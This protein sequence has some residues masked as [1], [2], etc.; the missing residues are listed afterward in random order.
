MSGEADQKKPFTVPLK[1]KNPSGYFEMHYPKIGCRIF[2]VYSDG[3]DHTSTLDGGTTT[4][5]QIPKIAG[6]SAAVFLLRRAR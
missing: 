4:P 2:A 3:K 5:H 1:I 6:G